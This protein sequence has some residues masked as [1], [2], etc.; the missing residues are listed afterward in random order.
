MHLVLCHSHTYWKQ[1][2]VPLH[3]QV[4]VPVK[5]FQDWQ[6]LLEELVLPL[7]SLQG[8]MQVRCRPQ[9]E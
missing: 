6:F 1:L 3:E 7:I 9:P 2:P 4:Q 5:V 8:S